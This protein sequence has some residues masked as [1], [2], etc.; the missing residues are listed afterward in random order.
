M[1]KLRGKMLFTSGDSGDTDL[2]CL[3]LASGHLRQLTT[4]RCRNAKG[5]WSPDG[6]RIAYL[7]NRLGPSD[8]WIMDGNG[9]NG[10]RL[11]SDNYWYDIADWSPDGAHLVCCAR[12]DGRSDNE[13]WVVAVPDGSRQRLVECGASD[14]Y[15]AWS[16]DGGRIAFTSSR[17]GVDDIWALELASR[18]L[19]EL[20][21]APG[22][23]FA[24]A[25]SPDGSQIAFVAARSVAFA[26]DLQ[27][28]TGTD[29]WLMSSDGSQQRRLTTHQRTDRCV[30]W[31]PDGKHLAYSA[32][33]RLWVLSVDTGEP[34]Q[35]DV[36]RGPLEGE[37]G[38]KPIG[39]F[40]LFPE[41]VVRRF[42]PANYF[43][44]ETYPHWTR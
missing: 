3:E 7:S 26:A 5:R 33:D 6:Q 16:P 40:S 9:Q 24:P 41:S 30:S 14:A 34:V 4:G 37:I 36:D 13:I 17:S 32:A 2:W 21:N 38:V 31:S 18:R 22:R 11:T 10:E 19:T 39:L 23:D 15:P 8:L 28:E 1:A 12:P 42:Y 44:S 27:G 25:W 35:L 29:V 20:T 43:G